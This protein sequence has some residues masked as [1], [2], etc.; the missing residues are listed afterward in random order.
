MALTSVCWRTL[1]EKDCAV[2]I[3]SMLG[4]TVFPFMFPKIYC[5]KLSQKLFSNTM[6]HSLK[7]IFFLYFSLRRYT[8]FYR[9][10]YNFVSFFNAALG[11]VL[12]KLRP[13]HILC[14]SLKKLEVCIN[15]SAQEAE[16]FPWAYQHA[17]N[18]FLLS[19]AFFVV[20]LVR[21]LGFCTA[22]YW[23]VQSL[24]KV[25]SFKIWMQIMP[26]FSLKLYISI[27]SCAVA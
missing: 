9:F 6:H 19:T 20:I 22:L 17:L 2:K 14:F 15:M 8:C 10:L 23:E 5:A 25:F 18:S 7:S 27:A 21:V 26:Y 12:T 1:W 24:Y 3:F 13:L 4:R 11:I 16:R